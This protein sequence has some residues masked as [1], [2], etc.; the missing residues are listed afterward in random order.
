MDLTTKNFLESIKESHPDLFKNS[1]VL[2]V[3][4]KDHNGTVREKFDNCEYSG[5]DIQ[6]GDGVDIVGHLCDVTDELLDNYDIVLCMNVLEHDSRWRDTHRV[7]QQSV[8]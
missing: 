3:G 5:V 8:R 2:E 1:R 4:S 7:L 6:D